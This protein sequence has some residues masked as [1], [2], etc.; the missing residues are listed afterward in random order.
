MTD[1]L[2]DARKRAND[3]IE[4]Y[5]DRL[6]E[7]YS[8]KGGYIRE[9]MDLVAKQVTDVR[10]SQIESDVSKL[11]KKV[12]A[13]PSMG[14]FLV[15]LALAALPIVGSFIGQTIIKEA[16][17]FKALESEAFRGTIAVQRRLDAFKS[18]I[19]SQS[20]E[21]RKKL[22]DPK[23]SERAFLRYEREYER[24]VGIRAM[25]NLKMMGT[26]DFQQFGQ[27]MESA[28]KGSFG[29]ELFEY[30]LPIIRVTFQML[31][32]ELM[33]RSA[34]DDLAKTFGK[35][36]ET[37]KLDQ[38]FKLALQRFQDSPNALLSFI[39]GDA[40]DRQSQANEKAKANALFGTSFIAWEPFLVH[41]ERHY[42][43]MREQLP[44]DDNLIPYKLALSEIL[45]AAVWLMFLPDPKKW[46]ETKD[47]EGNYYGVRG[48]MYQPK[49]YFY[50]KRNIPPEIEKHLLNTFR[51][52]PESKDTR[53][54]RDYYKDAKEQ[55]VPQGPYSG[56]PR[57]GVESFTIYRYKLPDKP[58]FPVE[59]I[60]SRDYTAEETALANL[61][62]YFV[63]LSEVMEQGKPFLDSIITK[64]LQ[65]L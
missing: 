19:L 14:L 25:S 27:S 2:N 20:G 43:Q 4:K 6:E 8:R 33:K 7:F 9:V 41:T 22:M 38:Y 28:I 58:E 12:F 13:S 51:P 31:G 52:Y 35:P 10:L 65:N 50:L 29:N 21:L 11:T 57:P 42:A 61:Q 24:I 53:N 18:E 56:V 63:R 60:R 34:N 44:H 3:A 16:K 59:D 5:F 15:D 49:A 64:N 30:T 17:S 40:C 62:S 37:M 39:V 32:T 45:E 26:K 46:M 48:N 1:D 36:Q 47:P 54:Y 55:S 23:L